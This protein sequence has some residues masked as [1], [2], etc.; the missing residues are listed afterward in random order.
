MRAVPYIVYDRTGQ[1]LRTGRCSPSLV[2][3]Q[4]GPGESAMVGEAR[5]SVQKI[6]VSGTEHRIMDLSPQEIAE[7]M[8]EFDPGASGPSGSSSVNSSDLSA[9]IADLSQRLAVLEAA[10]QRKGA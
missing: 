5:D 1:I 4:A 8:K 9:R 7:R 10:D 6:D 3:L 2:E